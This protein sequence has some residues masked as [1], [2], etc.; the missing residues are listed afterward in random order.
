MWKS[1]LSIASQTRLNV[2]WVEVP[3]RLAG[4]RVGILILNLV[5]ELFHFFLQVGNVIFHFTIVTIFGRI[6]IATCSFRIVHPSGMS[7]CLV[8]RS[9]RVVSECKWISFHSIDI[10]L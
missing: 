2:E 7:L 3:C 4:W 6:A 10:I 5:A 8:V 1:D 9:S